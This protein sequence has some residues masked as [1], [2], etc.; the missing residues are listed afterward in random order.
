MMEA[1]P[2]D[3]IS[4]KM[5]HSC[6]TA[7]GYDWPETDFSFCPAA[8]YYCPATSYCSPRKARRL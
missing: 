7:P 2:A 8:I 5:M 3:A 6:V 1:F 4:K